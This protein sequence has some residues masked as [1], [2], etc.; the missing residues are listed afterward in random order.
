MNEPDARLG[1]CSIPSLTR[2]PV[3][4]DVD[5]PGTG[6]IQVGPAMSPRGLQ[7]GT[8]VGEPLIIT[9]D[10]PARSGKSSTAERLA[11]DL[12]VYLLNTGVMYRA[13]AAEAIDA[14][15]DPSDHAGVEA[16]ARKMDMDFDYST[17][18]PVLLVYGKPYVRELRKG[19]IE[20]MVSAYSAIPGVRAI[21][22]KRQAEIGKRLG[23][24]VCEG[25]DQGSVVFP[26]A[27][28]KFYL[29]ASTPERARRWIGELRRAGENP[30]QIELERKI[31]A[32]DAS[33][34]RPD[35]VGR[36]IQPP[37]A[38]DVDSTSRT[39]EEVVLFMITHVREAARKRS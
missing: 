19:K 6:R 9:I 38:I 39:L 8:P 29:H 27:T 14:G 25:R 35:K 22:V 2:E 32:R 28:V 23:R 1:V 30:T 16:L 5:A 20:D 3:S 21:L 17:N 31:D 15:L 36:L 13:V 4:V 10:G 24:V 37:D 34:K 33:D 18:P 26:D 7:P 11:R 12:G